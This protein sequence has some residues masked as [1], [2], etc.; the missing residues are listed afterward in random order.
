MKKL[1]IYLL[2]FGVIGLIVGYFLFGKIA[3]EYVSLG[4]LLDF[5]SSGLAK[6]GRKISGVE[7][8]RKD[9]LIS[10]AVGAIVGIIIGYLKKK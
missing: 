1:L 8:I 2:V 9:I 10:G 3:G 6:F 7:A 4:S 5:S